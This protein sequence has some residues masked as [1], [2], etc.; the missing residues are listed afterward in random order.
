MKSFLGSRVTWNG[1]QATMDP[2]IPATTTDV[3]I[4]SIG[5]AKTFAVAVSLFTFDWQQHDG[6]PADS[7]C[8]FHLNPVPLPICKGCIA[9]KPPETFT[10]LIYCYYTPHEYVKWFRRALE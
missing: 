10:S 4:V 9:P 5:E 2:T 3:T 7:S 6:W 8:E 1:S